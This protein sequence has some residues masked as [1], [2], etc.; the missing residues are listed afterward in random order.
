MPTKMPRK[1]DLWAR[2]I[3]D[4]MLFFREVHLLRMFSFTSLKKYPAFIYQQWTMVGRESTCDEYHFQFTPEGI[5]PKVAPF[6][7]SRF[8]KRSFFPSANSKQ[9]NIYHVLFSNFSQWTSPAKTWT[10]KAS[11]IFIHTNPSR[12]TVKEGNISEHLMMLLV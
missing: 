12:P 7:E 5:W 3:V 9:W 8:V 10:K 11:N 1:A 6:L 4:G 2:I